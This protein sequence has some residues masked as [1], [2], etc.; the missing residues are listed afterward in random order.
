[1]CRIARRRPYYGA[2]A[3]PT[4][5]SA[6]LATVDS[7][8]RCPGAR[9]RNSADTGA[10]ATSVNCQGLPSGDA[11]THR[12]ADRHARHRC[13]PGRRAVCRGLGRGVETAGPARD[14]P[15]V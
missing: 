12:G 14:L 4:E 15:P 10:V 9:L 7:R 5:V 3:T 13:A 6:R 2:T 11:L 8:Y 1:M